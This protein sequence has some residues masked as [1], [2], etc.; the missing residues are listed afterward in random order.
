MDWW[1]GF[2]SGVLSAAGFV[3][4]LTF[5]VVWLSARKA[6]KA[7]VEDEVVGD[8]TALNLVLTRRYQGWTG[9]PGIG[10]AG[11]SADDQ[12]RWHDWLN[13]TRR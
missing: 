1:Q 10:P 11:S 7:L 3:F 13:A 9:Y 5:L 12:K 2:F 8:T 6:R 4:F